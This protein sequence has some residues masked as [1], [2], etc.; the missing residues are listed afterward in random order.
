MVKKKCQSNVL[1]E[2]AAAEGKWATV[3]A[4][5]GLLG[6]CTECPSKSTRAVGKG[7]FNYEHPSHTDPGLFWR[8]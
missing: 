4:W 3:Q 8:S 1:I 6:T 5:R 2:L 7:D